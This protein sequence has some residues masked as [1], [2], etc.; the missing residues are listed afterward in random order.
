MKATWARTVRVLERAESDGRDFLL[1]HEVYEVLK[2]AGIAAPRHIVVP[3]GR[4]VT[5]KDLSALGRGK[6]VVKVVSP[7]VVHKSDVGGVAFVKADPASV[8]KAIAAM[9]RSV[10][11]RYLAWARTRGGHGALGPS[12]SAKAVRES[13]RGFL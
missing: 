10:P 12:L 3:A 9:L 2:E 13:I 5:R 6:V 11:L 4:P 7:L 1:E 8:N